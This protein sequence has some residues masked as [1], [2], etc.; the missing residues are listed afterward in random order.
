MINAASG[1]PYDY[2]KPVSCNLRSE[3][4]RLCVAALFLAFSPTSSA[5][6]PTSEDVYRTAMQ[7]LAEG[8]ESDAR[9]ALNQLR[10]KIPDSA[11]A[12]LDLAILHCSLGDQAIAE[13][14][15]TEIES[16]FSPP[17][18][19]LEIIALQR[20]TQC[21]P[22]AMKRRRTSLQIT[23]GYDSNANQG[24]S[25]PNFSIGSG[26][27]RIELTVQPAFQPISDQYA[28]IS[29]DSREKRSSSKGYDSFIK[30]RL[31]SYDTLSHLDTGALIAGLE[32]GWQVN[33][34][35]FESSATAGFTSLGGKPYMYQMQVQ[36]NAL[37][38]T[39]LPAGWSFVVG[40]G[41][42]RSHYAELSSSDGYILESWTSL[43]KR[44]PNIEWQFNA[45][46][47]HD[48]AI[49]R[50]PGGNRSGVFG[51]IS[52]HFKVASDIEA[53]M[54]W[55]QQRWLSKER[56]APGLIDIRRDQASAL[57]TTTASIPLTKNSFFITE[58]QALKNRE[59]ISIFGYESTVLQFSWQYRL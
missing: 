39:P 13:A 2:S 24:A 53:E 21:K 37:V 33:D 17:A 10:N 4:V 49:N 50:R 52:V 59:N 8:R 55:Q 28:A 7:A 29:I 19:I 45:G 18:A 56:Y 51:V 57:F 3:K 41:L 25:N 20:A 15:F 5:T 27:N 58:I 32:E 43:R 47:M 23:R 48:K 9:D 54:S 12:W 14:L 6:E 26:I 16:R 42:A 38:P 31:R 30:L 35:K 36:A 34:W 1:T 22:A 46:A 40:G 44:R 11:G